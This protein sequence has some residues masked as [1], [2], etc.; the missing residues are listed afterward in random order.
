MHLLLAHGGSFVAPTRPLSLSSLTDNP[1]VSTAGFVS[2]FILSVQLLPTMR[3]FSLV[4]ALSE[5][6]SH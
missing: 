6:F 4:H 3:P 5:T 2:A 1:P